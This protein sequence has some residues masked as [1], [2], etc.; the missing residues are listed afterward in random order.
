VRRVG[1]NLAFVAILLAGTVAAAVVG[2]GY[3]TTTQRAVAHANRAPAASALRAS[4]LRHSTPI[5]LRIPAIGVNTA[6]QPLGLL[7]DGTLQPPNAWQTAGWYG[8]GV[9]PGDAGPAVIAGHVDSKSGPAVFYRLDRLHAGDLAV[10]Q[11]R[12]GRILRFVVDDVAVYPKS[13][14]PTAGVYGPT[15]LPMLR[16]VTCTGDFDSNAH[17][18]LSNLV[19]SAHLD[20]A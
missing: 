8:A 19:V 6:L 15:A 16:L 2:S 3:L 18:Y 14:F 13:A 7:A 10:V 9:V 20:T 4:A 17:T 11:R 1:A 5:R 12:D